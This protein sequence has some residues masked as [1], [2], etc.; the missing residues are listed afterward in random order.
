M[1][2]VCYHVKA[3]RP[4]LDENFQNIQAHLQNNKDHHPFIIPLLYSIYQQQ[5]LSELILL[6]R[7]HIHPLQV[8]FTYLLDL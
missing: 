4:P 1:L 3:V 7:C 6:S 2:N 5:P 8:F